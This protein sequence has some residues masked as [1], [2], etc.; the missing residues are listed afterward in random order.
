MSQ[1][2]LFLIFDRCL[3]LEVMWL[4]READHS[5]STD[6]EIKKTWVYTSAPPYPFI[7]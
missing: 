2:T 3:S 6:A 4:A 7:V 5:P 1:K